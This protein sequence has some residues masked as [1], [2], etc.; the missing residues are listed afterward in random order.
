MIWEE[1]KCIMENKKNNFCPQCGNKLVGNEKFC[2]V[3]GNALGNEETDKNSPKEMKG[4]Q[5]NKNTKKSG[6]K[7]KK[8]LIGAGGFLLVCLIIGLFTNPNES[9]QAGDTSGPETMAEKE[10]NE[11]VGSSGTN[12]DVV[13][14]LKNVGASIDPIFEL[15]D[16]QAEYIETHLELFP[17][18]YA[19]LEELSNSIDISLDYSHMIKNPQ[20]LAGRFT[21]MDKLAVRQIWEE[22][23]EEGGGVFDYLTGINMYDENGNN[24]YV[25]YI[26]RSTNLVE[27]DL[28]R[29][30]AMPIAYSS[31]KDLEGKEVLTLVM[32]AS[33]VENRDLSEMTMGYFSPITD[34]S[35]ENEIQEDIANAQDTYSGSE[36]GDAGSDEPD[37]GWEAEQYVFPGSDYR[38]YSEREL[39][40]YPKETLR[41]GR[42]EIYARHGRIFESADLRQ[43]FESKSWYHGYLTADEFD[44]SVLNQYERDNLELFK[45]M[46]NMQ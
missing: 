41:L 8:I 3:C 7:V 43:Y 5:A 25:Y 36:I 29:V 26:G 1:E 30:V 38:W 6:G 44:D 14:A 46:E 28:A 13:S 10:E 20:D 17:A 34:E 31:Y 4:L 22:N 15:T 39:E 32:A 27:G 2:S 33:M 23:Y 19:N 21:L 37:Y 45:T 9:N 11:T 12:I 18:A 16:R 40:G 24:Y 42:N 35:Q